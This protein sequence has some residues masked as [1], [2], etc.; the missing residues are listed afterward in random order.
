M[1]PFTWQAQQFAN[2]AK[3]LQDTIR[4]IPKTPRMTPSIRKIRVSE[5]T[6]NNRPVSPFPSLAC[7]YSL[8]AFGREGV[9]HLD[10]TFCQSRLLTSDSSSVL[11]EE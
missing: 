5:S 10:Q 2:F 4:T 8:L 9:F 7:P 11:A 6:K 1:T 3:K